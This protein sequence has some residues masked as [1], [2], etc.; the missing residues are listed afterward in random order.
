[1]S[2]SS[3]LIE[4]I[5]CGFSNSCEATTDGCC[6]GLSQG[7][8]LRGGTSHKSR[9]HT[10]QLPAI[11]RKLTGGRWAVCT[12]VIM[13]NECLM[14]SKYAYD[15]AILFDVD[16]FISINQTTMGRKLPVPLPQFLRQTFPSKVC[17]LS[18]SV[19]HAQV[20]NFATQDIRSHTTLC[21]LAVPPCHCWAAERQQHEQLLL[22]VDHNAFLKAC[23]VLLAV[24]LTSCGDKAACVAF[25]AVRTVSAVFGE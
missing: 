4:D 5:E 7:A 14:R 12:Q 19:D 11:A 18:P 6:L 3:A 25:P 21:T 8:Q 15:Y 24:S 17:P 2:S 1:V 10:G 20:P 9:L 16:E 22:T 23:S 13:Y